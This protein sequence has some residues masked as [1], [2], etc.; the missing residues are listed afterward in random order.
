MPY[1]VKL[2]PVSGITHQ[3]PSLLSGEKPVTEVTPH[4]NLHTQ[5]GQKEQQRITTAPTGL[6]AADRPL[7]WGLLDQWSTMDEDAWSVDS[8]ERLKNEILDFFRD[9]PGDAEKFFRGWRAA[10]PTARLA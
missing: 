7:F 5:P 6:L 4:G 1:K 8:V 10:H 2:P 9:H 3:G